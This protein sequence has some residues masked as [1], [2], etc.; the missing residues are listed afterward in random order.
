[1]AAPIFEARIG[2]SPAARRRLEVLRRR[3]EPGAVRRAILG[4]MRKEAT[5]AAGSVVRGMRGRIGSRTGLLR[6]SI[7]ARADFVRGAPVL[8]VGVFRGQA[9]RY[10]AA[11]ELG[12]T[13]LPRR[14]RAL[15][16][17]GPDVLTRTG[18]DRYG[19]PKNYP[20][21]LHFVPFKRGKN[22]IG[23]LF[24]DEQMA[25][26][27]RL[28]KRGVQNALRQVKAAYILLRRSVLK[29]REFLRFGFLTFLPGFVKRFES[30][31][32]D[33]FGGGK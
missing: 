17:P 29:P 31:L 20:G 33:L 24:S 28:R 30:F 15:A 9:K 23:A 22:A 13:I 25:R 1:M 14:R 7:G 19:G 16:M 18:V 2:L 11:Q 10:A 8:K 5:I 6:Q 27:R 12:A 26:Y 32:K 3:A 4:F 21:D